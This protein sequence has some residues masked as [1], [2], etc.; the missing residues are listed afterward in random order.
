MTEL[1]W[2][3]YWLRIDEAGLLWYGPNSVDWIG[4]P[5]GNRFKAMKRFKD[6]L[7][8]QGDSGF[9]LLLGTLPE[10]F[11]LNQLPDEEGEIMWVANRT[12]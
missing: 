1:G 11:F 5:S 10:N 7:L 9:F 8:L 12:Y 3:D 2:K 6:D 4:L